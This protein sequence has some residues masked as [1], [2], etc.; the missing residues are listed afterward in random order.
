MPSLSLQIYLWPVTLTFDLL[1]PKVE[2]FM[3]L[4]REPLKPWHRR[5]DDI[6]VC[7]RSLPIIM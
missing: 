2:R 3:P 7:R 6:P 5:D 1:T 4:P